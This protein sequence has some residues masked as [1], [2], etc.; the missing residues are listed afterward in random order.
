MHCPSKGEGL[1]DI[2]HSMSMVLDKR[3]CTFGSGTLTE[4]ATDAITKCDSYFVVK[5][6]KSLLQN[7]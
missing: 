5:Y 4:N 1:R 3:K 7:V 6:G 2:E